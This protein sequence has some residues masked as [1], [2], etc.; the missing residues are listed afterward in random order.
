MRYKNVNGEYIPIVGTEK[1]DNEQV[2]EIV[3]ADVPSRLADIE[4]AIAELF[5]K[6]DTQS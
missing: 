3:K 1:T 4:L 6:G 2:E 5:S